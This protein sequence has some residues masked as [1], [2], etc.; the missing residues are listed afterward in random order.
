LIDKCVNTTFYLG[1]IKAS[2][3]LRDCSNCVIHVACS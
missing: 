1:P 2:V 3:F